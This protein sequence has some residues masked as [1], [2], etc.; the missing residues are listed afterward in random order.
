M[1]PLHS[2]S[3]NAD[4]RYYMV[5]DRLLAAF[6]RPDGTTISLAVPRDV[7]MAGAKW[8]GVGVGIGFVMWCA[9]MSKHRARSV[10]VQTQSIGTSGSAFAFDLCG[11]GRA[12]RRIDGLT[13]VN[14]CFASAMENTGHG[15]SSPP[16]PH[17][18]GQGYFARTLASITITSSSSQDRARC[19]SRLSPC[20][21]IRSRTR[22]HLSWT[23]P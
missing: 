23:S 16:D 9:W 12:E 21:A 10:T 17:H 4:L 1:L 11:G 18:R 22:D 6:S 14:S 2:G 13:T 5:D 7:A 19:R 20:R 3:A 15:P 8:T